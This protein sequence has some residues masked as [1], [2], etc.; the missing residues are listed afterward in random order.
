M[1]Q[2]RREYEVTM[3]RKQANERAAKEQAKPL[4]VR[5]LP[6]PVR[7]CYRRVV[8]RFLRVL[9]R[10]RSGRFWLALLVYAAGQWL[11]ARAQFGLVFFIL[12]L[13]AAVFLNLEWVK[14]RPRG[15]LSAYSVFNPGQRRLAGELDATEYDRMLRGGGTQ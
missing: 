6:K 10:E 3:A 14:T 7:S 1:A 12:A 13:V 8:P 9:M 5:L 2:Q 15:V 4:Y 11:A